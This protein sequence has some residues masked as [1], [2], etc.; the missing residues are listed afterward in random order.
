MINCLVF[1]FD[2]TLV[3]S[4]SIKRN[5]YF[6]AATEFAN[7]EST[8]ADVLA[9]EPGNR[10]KV[11]REIVR[12][13]EGGGKLPA[14]RNPEAWVARLVERYTEYCQT[15]IV[16]CPEVTGMRAALE[17][18]A[19]GGYRLFINSATPT[20]PLR[21]IIA[22]RGMQHQFRNVLGGPTGKADNLRR[23]L[24]DERVTKDETVM[25]GDNEADR[26]AAE[27]IG[28]HFIGLENEF[29]GYSVAPDR[30]IP[31]L[32]CLAE[33]V[34]ALPARIRIAANGGLSP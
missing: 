25:I 27:E 1:D 6:E 18:L 8:V 29:S 17:T 5:A 11:F 23:I 12:V 13:L 20:E 10:E 3:Q 16:A 21:N 15:A 19:A 28:C 34:A 14:S 33:A 32:T 22:L 7:A 24:A 31:D 26:L 30:L 2:G 4:N 9:R